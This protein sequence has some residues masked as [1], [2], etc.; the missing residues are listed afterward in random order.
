MLT[1]TNEFVNLVL[2]GNS[3][4]F[5]N[6]TSTADRIGEK[7]MALAPIS[8]G[9]TYKNLAL[10]GATFQMML[11]GSDGSGVAA[12]HAAF[13][14][15]KQNILFVM[16]G[17]NSANYG[18]DTAGIIADCKAYID[19]VKAV[20]PEWRVFI[21]IALAFQNNYAG[22]EERNGYIDGYNAYV[23]TNYADL[24]AEGFV[25]TRPPGGPL[26]FTSPYNYSETNF[27]KS[28]LYQDALHPN[29][30][31]N[32]VLAQYGVDKLT[33]IPDVAPDAV[34][35]Q[36]AGGSGNILLGWP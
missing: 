12:V 36:S 17:V 27:T 4:F 29:A 13:E 11:N 20:H 31:G 26:A 14:P 1:F 25:E 18:R 19:A 34:V 6:A 3:L 21:W 28:G 23:R 24:G 2:D 7:M 10:G 35:T 15:G 32:A 22:D 8:G 16:E 30:A 33:T 5:G 9:M